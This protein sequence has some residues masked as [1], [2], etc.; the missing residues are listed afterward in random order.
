LF[1][2]SLAFDTNNTIAIDSG[3]STPL[4][5]N[6]AS[7]QHQG[8]ALA[9][10]ESAVAENPTF[11]WGAI[12]DA[13]TNLLTFTGAGGGGSRPVKFAGAYGGFVGSGGGL[14]S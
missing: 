8:G 14:V 1:V 13:A 11:S 6:W 2:A 10:K 5:T 3:F 9:W 7:S 4:Q 12:T